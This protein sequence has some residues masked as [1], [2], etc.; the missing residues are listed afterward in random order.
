MKVLFII[1]SF[2]NGGTITSLINLLN[3]IDRNRY[4][5]EILAILPIGPR[6]EE[7][8]KFAKVLTPPIDVQN[9]RNNRTIRDALLT[10]A[11]KIKK[12]LC[13]IGIDIS[14]LAFFIDAKKW[15]KRGYDYVIGFQEGQATL[16]ASF[17]NKT[18]RACWVHCDY[19]NMLNDTHI[20]PEHALYR[21][22]DKIICVSKYSKD[23]FLSLIPEVADKTYSVYNCV[24]VQRIISKSK[25]TIPEQLGFDGCTKIVSLGRLDP[26]KHFSIIPSIQKS[27]LSRGIQNKWFIIGGGNDKERDVIE[28]EIKKY[29]VGNSVILLGNQDNPYSLLANSSIVVCTSLSEACPYV[30]NEAKVL[31]IPIVTT[32]FCSASEFVDSGKNGIISSVEHIDD[33]IFNLLTDKALYSS[34]QNELRANIFDNASIVGEINRILS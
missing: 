1:P 17:F 34:I 11:L 21:K 26:V 10:T 33:D 4:E 30:I 2:R 16:F 6:Y 7:L 3:Y 32:D 28:E 25:E 22:F 29:D 19:K 23:S 15:E 18:K 20:K 9:N 14:A 27:L 24:N 8:A 5:V 12:G 31:G 13:K